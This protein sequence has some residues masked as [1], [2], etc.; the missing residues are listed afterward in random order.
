MEN[1]FE[2]VV[3]S[4]AGITAEHPLAAVLLGRGSIMELT[5]KSHDAVLTPRDCGGL[6]RPVRA[7]LA[8]RISRHNGEPVLAAHFHGMIGGAGS[9]PDSAL[10]IADPAFDGGDDTR[11][12][13]VIHY[14]DLVAVDP[15]KAVA[16]DIEKLTKA[17]VPDDDIV[18]LS[19]L[20]AF[21][22]YQIRLVAGLRLMAAV[23]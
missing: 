12:K 21:V 22:S 6:S 19:E 18:R 10:R 11:L 4:A 15:K 7:A 23:A 8:C 9:E 16:Q 13:A 5:Q 1:L 14:A 3:P 20:I 2:T 17:G